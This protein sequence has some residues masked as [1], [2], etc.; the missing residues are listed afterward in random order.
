MN[1]TKKTEGNLGKR[2]S[3]P[4]QIQSTCQRRCHPVNPY[5]LML[6]SFVW[7]VGT[8]VTLSLQPDRPAL[9]ILRVVS[10]ITIIVP[11]IIISRSPAANIRGRTRHSVDVGTWLLYAG[12][13]S[14]FV[15]LFFRLCTAWKFGGTYQEFDFGDDFKQ[16]EL[17]TRK[18]N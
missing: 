16:Y 4:R 14:L 8:V 7:V 12:F 1:K 17:K 9:P 10:T 5:F 3:I 13:L 2:T 11:T 18:P 15:Q 6:T